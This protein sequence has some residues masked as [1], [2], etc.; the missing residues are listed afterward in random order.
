MARFQV[1]AIWDAEAGV[2]A[3]TSSDV[4]GLAA[5]GATLDALL[6]KIK[7]LIPELLEENGEPAEPGA[8]IDLTTL[9][10]LAV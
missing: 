10:P 5:E 1:N 7:A 2:Y 8:Q 3:V 4:P 6:A 9:A